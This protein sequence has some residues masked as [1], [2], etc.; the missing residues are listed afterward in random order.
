MSERAA[1]AAVDAA[2]AA[3]R[4]RVSLEA[5]SFLDNGFEFEDDDRVIEDYVALRMTIP[6]FSGGRQQGP[7]APAASSPGR[8][9][10]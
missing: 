10:L 4:P 6:I 8:S 5:N 1:D 2:H 3:G 9:A 7:G